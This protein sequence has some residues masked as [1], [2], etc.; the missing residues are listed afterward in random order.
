[1]LSFF[2]GRSRKS[3]H[4]EMG[5]QRKSS[6]KRQSSLSKAASIAHINPDAPIVLFMGMFKSKQISL[7]TNYKGGPGGG[8]TKHAARIRDE[9]E[10]KGLAH[11]CVPDLIKDA[12]S[13]YKDHY[14][15][16]K[17]A[18]RHYERGKAFILIKIFYYQYF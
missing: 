13:R 15:E 1:M 14:P 17:E 9:F 5:H 8:K 10:E 12:I 16:W 6:L 11:I 2:S 18:A 4:E 3:S 7:I